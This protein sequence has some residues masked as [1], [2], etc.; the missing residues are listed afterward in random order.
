MVV[1]TGLCRSRA[2]CEFL[3]T[4]AI[5]A[6]IIIAQDHQHCGGRK[7]DRRLRRTDPLIVDGEDATPGQSPWLASL[8]Q[9]NPAENRWKHF[10]TGAVIDR[11]WI[12]TAGHCLVRRVPEKA[13]VAL[14]KFNLALQEPHELYMRP[15][16][17]RVAP[18][19]RASD[20][21]PINTD[22]GMVMLS[23]ALDLEGPHAHIVPICLPNTDHDRLFLDRIYVL[24]GWGW[25][26]VDH[27]DAAD[28]L[29]RVI[30][31]PVDADRCQRLLKNDTA[32][33]PLYFCA[34]TVTR[35]FPYKGDSGA[36]FQFRHENR[37]I[38]MGTLVGY[39]TGAPRITL[40]MNVTVMRGWIDVV[41][42][43]FPIVEDKTKYQRGLK[44]PIGNVSK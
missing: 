25:T 39:L 18:E 27:G 6:S 44:R 10:C 41:R 40:Y 22:L 4:L 35:A 5:V 26:S 43:T 3:V 29:Q 31:L 33:S 2:L 36:P 1:R 20:D 7:C 9:W 16:V 19:Y 32:G 34:Q 21:A 8:Q 23:T 42:A 28:V 15:K 24:A 38:A 14:G 13:R 12:L 37:T 11:Q 30:L 17:Y